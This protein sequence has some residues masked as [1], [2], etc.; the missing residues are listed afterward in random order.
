MRVGRGLHVGLSAVVRHTG[1]FRT[2]QVD[3]SVLGRDGI[4]G[5]PTWGVRVQSATLNAGNFH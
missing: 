3:S 5:R 4:V 1:G 2:L